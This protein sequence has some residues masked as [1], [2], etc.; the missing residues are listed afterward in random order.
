MRNR[1]KTEASFKE[2]RE[3]RTVICIMNVDMQ[4]YRFES[5][6]IRI[7]NSWY[8]KAPMVNDFGKFTVVGKAKCNAEDSYDY[9]TGRKLAESRAK[10]KAFKIASNVW[11]SI[12][13]SFNKDKED[14]ENMKEACKIALKVELEHIDKL[15]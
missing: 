12:A 13:E 9:E 5:L 11:G 7:A 6:F 1:V 15:K 4:L 3:K 8:K 10:A 14:A 2:N